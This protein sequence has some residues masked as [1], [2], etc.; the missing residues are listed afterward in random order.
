MVFM[1]KMEIRIQL[2]LVCETLLCFL[3]EI[4]F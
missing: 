2:Y 3:K 1:E 4:P